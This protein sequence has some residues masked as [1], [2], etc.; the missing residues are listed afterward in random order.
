[1]EKSNVYKRR[2]MLCL[3]VAV[4]IFSVYGIRLFNWQILQ[5]DE[6]QETAKNNSTYSLTSDR[7]RGEI[8]TSDGK[9]LATNKTIYNVVLRYSYADKDKLNETVRDV[10][11]ILSKR[12]EKWIDTLPIVYKNNGYSFNKNDTADEMFK[13]LHSDEMLGKNYKNADEYIR[14]L[15]KMYKCSFTDKQTLRDVISVRVNMDYK[16][17]GSEN[18]YIIAE[19]VSA[20][21]MQIISE[22]SSKL[23]GIEISTTVERQYKNGTLAP[24]IVGT[25]GKISAEE[26]K[27]YSDKGYGYNDMIGKFG[28]EQALEEQ[29]RG[30]EG[31]A[32][33]QKNGNGSIIKTVETENA[34]PGNTVWLTLDSELQKVANEALAYNVNQSHN[35]GASD[36]QAGAVVMLD[37]NDFSVLAAATYPSYDI[38]KYSNYDYYEKLVN[39]ESS[40]LYSRAFD[41]AFA[42]GSVFKPCVALAGLEEKKITKDSYITCTQEYDYYPT[43]IVKC[44]GYHGAINM[45][46]ALAVSCNYYFAEVGRRLGVDS[47]YSYAEKFGLGLRTGVE[48]PENIGILAGRDSTSWMEGNT[49]QAAIGQSDNA[50][51]PAQLASYA[52]TIANNGKRLRTHIVKKITSYDRSQTLSETTADNVNVLST[53]TVDKD[54]LK[55]VQQGMWSVCNDYN[56]TAYSVFGNYGVKV[57]AK[58]GTAENSGTDHTVFICYAPFDKPQVAIAVVIEHGA[59]TTYSSGVAK[60]LMNKYFFNKDYDPDSESVDEAGFVAH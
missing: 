1:M 52:A 19:D 14:E 37:V 30:K 58:T 51:T 53:L 54:N 32:Y 48:I 27:T 55:T 21:M 45:N 4:L 50:F 20:D 36:C 23:N 43:D 28:I 25:I 56:G 49:V 40:P 11:D 2:G 31:K 57:A 60:A 17:Y 10:L 6:Y 38:S 33:V 34:S 29:L 42:P 15:S 26:Y 5:G 3:A 44:M 22:N 7:T 18:D 46:T 12:N 47:I 24:H 39:D 13:F 16:N 59:Y 41:G 9:R 35:N 8:L